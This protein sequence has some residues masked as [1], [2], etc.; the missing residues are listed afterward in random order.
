MK[1]NMTREQLLR[2]ESM[3]ETEGGEVSWV[4]GRGGGRMSKWVRV[5]GKGDGV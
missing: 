3:G 4:C 5:V 2:K 1:G